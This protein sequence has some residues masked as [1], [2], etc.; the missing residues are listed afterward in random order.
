MLFQ[1]LW[2]KTNNWARLE[3]YLSILQFGAREVLVQWQWGGFP[4]K[5]GKHSRFSG[6]C[7]GV[8]TAKTYSI[9]R[10]DAVT[11]LFQKEASRNWFWSTPKAGM[12]W[13][14]WIF[15]ALK[16]GEEGLDFVNWVANQIT[17]DWTWEER[18]SMG[19]LGMQNHEMRKFRTLEVNIRKSIRPNKKTK[20]SFF[21][22]TDFQLHTSPGIPGR[23][24][25]SFSTPRK[26]QRS[27]GPGVA[28]KKVCQETVLWRLGNPSIKLLGENQRIKGNILTFHPVFFFNW[29]C[30]DLSGCHLWGNHS[31][32]RFQLKTS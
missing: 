16:A 17:C 14:C 32:L 3:A 7:T 28:N 12:R 23:A 13:S 31:L 11:Y 10:C 22:S 27:Q 2:K 8:R 21:K 25:G 29:G 4:D 6:I 1:D 19:W 15:G 26:R 20:F 30:T 5:K 18:S 24:N 9:F